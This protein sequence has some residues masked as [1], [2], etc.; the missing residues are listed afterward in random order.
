MISIILP[1]YNSM[2]F[3]TPRLESIFKQ[4]YTDYEVVVVD[5][6]SKDGTWEKMEEVA[7]G[8]SRY[9]LFRC[10][11]KGSLNAFNSGVRE[12]KGELIY[13]A[14]SDDTMDHD[15]LEKMVRRHE[16]TG[17]PFLFSNLQFVDEEEKEILPGWQGCLLNRLFEKERPTVLKKPLAGLLHFN[18]ALSTVWT[19]LTQVLAVREIYFEK[20]FWFP[21]EYGAIGDYAWDARVGLTHDVVYVEDATATW[22]IHGTQL[23]NFD[24]WDPELRKK[25]L[26]MSTETLE[27]C[28][29]DLSQEHY[30]LGKALIADSQKKW[31][32]ESAILGKNGAGPIASN[33]AKLRRVLGQC[34]DPESNF[35]EMLSEAYLEY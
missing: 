22:R 26:R 15:F 5:S 18:S 27:L 7:A 31:E 2:E 4:T 20:E 32:M 3:L 12:A 10:E 21:E 33:L 34:P 8:D 35:D 30:E 1:T 9:R 6:F 24:L 17:A 11:P 29:P 23:T 16:E 14:T 25:H 13:I 19:S 28:R